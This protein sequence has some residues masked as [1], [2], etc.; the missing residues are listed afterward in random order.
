MLAEL[1]AH[2]P[3][4]QHKEEEEEE[5]KRRD[6]AHTPHTVPPSHANETHT[7]HTTLPFSVHNTA[8]QQHKEEADSTTRGNATQ[9]G[10]GQCGVPNLIRRQGTL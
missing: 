7:T 1:R 6:H 2:Y 8:T 9:K 10:T 3:E 4:H 5:D